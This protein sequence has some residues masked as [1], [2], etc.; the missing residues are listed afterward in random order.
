MGLLKSVQA[1]SVG[2]KILLPG[3]LLGPQDQSDE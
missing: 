2:L 1:L 3:D